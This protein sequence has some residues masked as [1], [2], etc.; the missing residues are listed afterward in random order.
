MIDRG[1]LAIVFAARMRRSGLL[2][3]FL[4]LCVVLSI[5]SNRFLTLP[6]ALNILRQSSINGIIAAGMT[7]VILTAGIDLSVGSVLALSSVIT[8]QLLVS[9][10]PPLMAFFSGL[11][12]GALLG[13][14]NGILVTLFS[15]PPFVATLGTMT[16]AR[17][18][19]LSFTQGKPITGLPESFRVLGTGFVGPIP[20]PVIIVLAVFLIGMFFLNLTSQG[21]QLYALGNNPVAARFTG[22]LVKLYIIVVYSVAGVLAALAGQILIARLDSA[23]PVMGMGYELDAIAAV[24]VGGSNFNGGSGGL[25]GTLI[26]VLF[27]VVINNGLNLL[28]IPSF[29]GQ[30][31]KG[32]VIAMALLFNRVSVQERKIDRESV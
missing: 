21:E 19:A 23:Q 3:A 7:L 25:A 32:V 28:N 12:V 20:V 1:S 5:L 8:A 22:I 31:V 27:I 30:V 26:G 6:N 17:G 2:L 10:L 24:V 14:F 11:F 13:L 15:L 4:A 16:F 18:L 29:W 9:G